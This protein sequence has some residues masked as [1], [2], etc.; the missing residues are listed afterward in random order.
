[1][2]TKTNNIDLVKNNESAIEN[3]NSY[4]G[5]D[6]SETQHIQVVNEKNLE[7]WDNS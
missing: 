5:E 2:V 6:V 1:M 7:N 3:P 4:I